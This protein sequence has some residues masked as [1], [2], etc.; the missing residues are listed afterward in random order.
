MAKNA[1]LLKNIYLAV[2][3]IWNKTCV[4]PFVTQ[5]DLLPA[6]CIIDDNNLVLFVA[7]SE[8]FV[9]MDYDSHDNF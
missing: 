5:N 7:C 4:L 3:H 2:F 8:D 6:D 9:G 1:T